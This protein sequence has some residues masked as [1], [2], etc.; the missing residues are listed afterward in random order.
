MDGDFDNLF[1]IETGISEAADVL[2]AA[3]PTPPHP[4]A[5]LQEAYE[6]AFGM[7]EAAFAAFDA[8]ES[9]ALI[10]GYSTRFSRS[11]V[12]YDDM[13]QCAVRKTVEVFTDRMLG[14]SASLDAEEEFERA[15][16]KSLHEALHGDADLR[17]RRRDEDDDRQPVRLNLLALWDSM[18]RV[19][20][21]GGVWLARH[22]AANAIMSEWRLE[23]QAFEVK[24]GKAL[25]EHRVYSEP[26]ESYRPYR[27]VHYNYQEGL[28]RLCKA[29]DVFF[30]YADLPGHAMGFLRGMQSSRGNDMVIDSGSTHVVVPGLAQVRT[31]NEQWKWTMRA[32]VAEK[33]REFIAAFKPPKQ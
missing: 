20:D 26:A 14:G 16:G 32:D 23:S 31:F 10:A 28:Y 12:D 9:V 3:A 33:L 22:Q 1:A 24:N 2:E 4:A 7:F 15:T 25:I 18:A 29:L 17:R 13:S 19:Y 11:V 5:H 6:Q 21:D 27:R 8:A 30:D